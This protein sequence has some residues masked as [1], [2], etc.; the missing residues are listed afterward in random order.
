[1]EYSDLFNTEQ[2]SKLQDMAKTFELR[3]LIINLKGKSYIVPIEEMEQICYVIGLM[4]TRQ[5]VPKTYLSDYDVLPNSLI[6]EMIV[7]P[8]K[9]ESF[10]YLTDSN[11]DDMGCP[12][13]EVIPIDNGDSYVMPDNLPEEQVLAPPNLEPDQ[14]YLKNEE[15]D[16]LAEILDDDMF[17]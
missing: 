4:S 9:I 14:E 2:F 1:M 8:N 15:L 10:L 6:I 17:L 13:H 7:K 11:G 5:D 12:A 3:N 16:M